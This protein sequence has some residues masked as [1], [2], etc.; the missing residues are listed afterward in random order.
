MQ[1]FLL[2]HTFHYERRSS[3][4]CFSSNSGATWV[5]RGLLKQRIHFSSP[6][7]SS[8]EKGRRYALRCIKAKKNKFQKGNVFTWEEIRFA[9]KSRNSGGKLLSCCYR[10]SKS[11]ISSR[12]P[13]FR[14]VSWFCL[15]RARCE[16]IR[17]TM[18]H[19]Y[20]DIARKVDS[21]YFNNIATLLPKRVTWKPLF[22]EIIKNTSDQNLSS[23]FGWLVKAFLY[24]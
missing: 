23:H 9:A 18:W 4:P 20:F 21:W 12:L 19:T 22:C 1:H 16:L 3:T 14:S 15:R 7:I 11:A 2:L 8:L 13:E 24:W 17:N 5:F 6:L 10:P